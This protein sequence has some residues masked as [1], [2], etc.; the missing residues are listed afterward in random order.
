MSACSPRNTIRA[1]RRLLG[2]FPQALTH[3]ALINTA[4]NLS[5]GGPSEHRSGGMEQAPSCRINA[6]G[7]AKPPRAQV[8]T[9]K[10]GSRIR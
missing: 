6:R 4:R 7:G 10:P 8:G 5:R 1:P 9:L 2:N 3:V